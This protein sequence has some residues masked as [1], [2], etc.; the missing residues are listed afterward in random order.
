MDK[1]I[2]ALDFAVHVDIDTRLW[3]LNYGTADPAEIREMVRLD[4]DALIKDHIERTGN[5]GKVRVTDV[6]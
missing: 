1:H 2:A 4:I 3:A 5:E 6:R